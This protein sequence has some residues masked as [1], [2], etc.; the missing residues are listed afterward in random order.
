MQPF[1]HDM[2]LNIFK[3]PIPTVLFS[4]IVLC[5]SWDMVRQDHCNRV[6]RPVHTCRPC[7]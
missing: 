2:Q 6:S 7:L 4:L 3:G 5:F 1:D